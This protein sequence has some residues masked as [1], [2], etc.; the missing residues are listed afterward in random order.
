M[1]QL[2]INES[3]PHCKYVRLQSNNDHHPYRIDKNVSTICQNDNWDIQSPKLTAIPE[4]WTT[5][6]RLM[7]CLPPK[8]LS[9]S[10]SSYQICVY[11]QNYLAKLVPMGG[12]TLNELMILLRIDDVV[13]KSAI[14]NC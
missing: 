9:S 7:I 5:G 4:R 12:R 13:N 2:I 14:R 6:T 10:L 1:F 11:Q 3:Q 8:T